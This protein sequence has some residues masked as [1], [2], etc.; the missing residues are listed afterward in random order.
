MTSQFD[1]FALLVGQGGVERLKKSRVAVFGVGGVGGHCAEALCRAGIGSLDI[2]DGDVVSVTNIN[3]QVVALHSTIGLDK[4]AVMRERL[5]DINP[6]AAIVARKL[7]YLPETAGDVDLSAYDY[8]VDAVDT[9]TAKLELACR[10]H[11]LGVPLISSMGAANKLDPT[12]FVVADIYE[13]SVCPL[14]R[15]MRTEL[16]KRGVLSLKVVYSRE[17]PIKPGQ[18]GIGGAEWGKT[19]RPLPASCSFVP[20]AAG[21]II[22]GEVIKDLMKMP[23]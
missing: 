18:G 23:S 22:A 4:A 16:R 14:A 20:P 21:L 7:F 1:R 5:M 13:T 2:F 8:V 11:A 9:V 15:I 6:E 10:A 19:S 3:R 17:T 12:A